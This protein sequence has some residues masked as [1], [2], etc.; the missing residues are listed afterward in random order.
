MNISSVP[1][2]VIVRTPYI[3]PS[4]QEQQKEPEADMLSEPTGIYIEGDVYSSKKVSFRKMSQSELTY[5][6]ISS[7]SSHTVTSTSDGKTFTT[8]TIAF[9]DP[10]DKDKIITLELSDEA[11]DKLKEKFGNKDFFERKDGILRLNGKAE[12]YV[13][14]WVDDIKNKRNYA[15][16]DMDGDGII[17]GQEKGLLKVG[18]ERRTEYDFVKDKIVSVRLSMGDNYQSLGGTPTA[19]GG[20]DLG[21]KTEGVENSVGAALESTIMMDTDFDGNVSMLEMNER[22]RGENLASSILQSLQKFHEEQVLTQGDN[23]TKN[24]ISHYDIG[25]REIYSDEEI[26]AFQKEQREAAKMISA[27]FAEHRIDVFS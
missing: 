5:E 26:E 15:K 27:Y 17:S 11:I 12:E 4:E 2:A 6:K 21:L 10:N 16:A 19:S 14:G 23:A 25:K 22:Y 9:R 24:K 8:N 20:Y 7:S 18:F 13:A 3:M 1:T